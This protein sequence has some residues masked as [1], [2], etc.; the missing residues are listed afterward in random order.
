MGVWQLMATT[1]SI[2]AKQARAVRALLVC[3]SIPEAAR[4]TGFGERTLHRWMK[5]PAFRQALADAENGLLDATQRRLV[6]L[7]EPAL[8][9]LEDILIGIADAPAGVQ[10]RAAELA[11]S[12]TL[13]MR[14]A[15]ELEARLAALEAA[16][17]TQGE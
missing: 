6:G 17:I 7:N 9:V 13:K 15:R 1:G 12:Y 11:L 3:K 14:E 10:L 16:I 5:A 8:D 4:Q 2:A